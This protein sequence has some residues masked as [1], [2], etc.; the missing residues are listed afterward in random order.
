[1]TYIFNLLALA[2]LICVAPHVPGTEAA[3]ELLNQLAKDG[4]IAIGSPDVEAVVR[5]VHDI[6]HDA[7]HGVLADVKAWMLENVNKAL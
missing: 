2:V 1:M 4:H 6:G 3:V 7:L 5:D